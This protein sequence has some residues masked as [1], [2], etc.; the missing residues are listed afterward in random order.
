MQHTLQPIFVGFEEAAEGFR[1]QHLFSFLLE[2]LMEIFPFHP[3]DSF[4]VDAESA[5]SSFCFRL[6]VAAVSLSFR[7]PIV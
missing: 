7:L 5:F 6:K 2:Y 4:V 3:V 1:S